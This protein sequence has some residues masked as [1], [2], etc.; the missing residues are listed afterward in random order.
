VLHIVTWNVN[1][2]NGPIKRTAC[3]DYLHRQKVD[4]AF[5]Q[6]SH[7]RKSDVQR[8]SNKFY[9]VAASS[10]LDSKSRGTLVVLKRKLSFN[11]LERYS[12]EEGRVSY[13]KTAI[14]GRNF[15]F[16][17]IYAPSHFD[18]QFFSAVTKTLLSI[19][20]C[21]LIIGAD[22]NAVVDV[23]LDRSCVQ[24]YS[25]SSL[26]SIELCKFMSDLSLIDIYRIFYPTKRQY[27][28]YSARHKSYSRLDY[29][30]ISQAAHSVV[31]NV[32]I[33]SCPLSDHNIVSAKISLVSAPTKAP[34]W[35]FNTTLLQ[36]KDFC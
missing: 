24:N 31:H 27:T 32:D 36:N 19:Q 8:F 16:I 30:L 34:R 35:R 26:S 2:L 10:S 5:I 23:S 15:A 7:L 22:M 29:I 14:A 12:C 33:K 4:L 17:S 20:D 9:F 13:I 28:F 6:E 3:L 25:G 1:G 11:I 18:P 21:F